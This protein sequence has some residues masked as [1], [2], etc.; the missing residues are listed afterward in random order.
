[1]KQAIIKSAKSIWQI[2]PMLLSILLL[3]GI[4]NSF[5]TKSVYEKIFGHG[6]FFDSIIGA[7]FGSISGG[8]PVNSY[9]LGGEFLKSGVSLTAVTAFIVAWVSV[10]I[11]QLPFEGKVLGFRF[12]VWRNITAFILAIIVAVLTNLFMN[13]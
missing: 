10:G 8:S 4:I 11:I 1:M 7:I 5:L 2:I 13:L 6:T 3:I 9:V 12:A